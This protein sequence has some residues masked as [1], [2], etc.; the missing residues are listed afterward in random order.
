MTGPY[1]GMDPEQ[2]RTMASQLT[3]G[4]QQ[5]RDLASSLGAQ[6]EAT[7]WTGADRDQFLS[8]WQSYHVNS[9]LHVADAIDQ[10][11]QKAVSN[12]EQQ[13]QASA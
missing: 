9:L 7:P 2:V 1:L 13:E 3:A 11:S 10:A 12:A 6:I 4:A 8:D 5:V